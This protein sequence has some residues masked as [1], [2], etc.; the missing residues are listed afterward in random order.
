VSDSRPTARV[1]VDVPD[2]LAR[3]A[4]WVLQTLCDAAGCRLEV[5]RDGELSQG[6]VL[7]YAPRPIGGVPTIPVSAEAAAAIAGGADVPAGSFTGFDSPAPLVGAFPVA[8]AGF[9]LPFDLVASAFVILAAWDEHTRPQ[10]DQ[11]GRFPYELSFFATEAALD[12]ADPPLDGYVRVLR[13]LL[14]QTFDLTPPRWERRSGRSFAAPDDA[15][16]AHPGE[17]PPATPSD[18]APA[19]R[20]DGATF[21]IA[22]THDVDHLRRWT[23]RA[24]AGSLRRAAL[25]ARAGDYATA[26]WEL[27]CLLR[28]LTDHLPA[29]SDPYWTFPDLIEREDRLGVDCTFF[30]IAS[31]RERLD[32]VDASDYH[33]RLPAL[34]RLLRRAARETGLHGNSRDRVDLTALS[35]DRSRLKEMTAGAVEGIRFHYLR[36]LYHETLPML[37][38]AGFAYDSSIAFGAREGPR[39]GLSFPFRPYFLARDR[40]LDLVELPLVI[41]DG[42]LQDRHYRDLPVAEGR[43][44]AQRVLAAV[45]DVGG[46]AAVLWH[47]TRLDPLISRGYGKV[48]WDLI[49]W[50]KANGGVATSA[51]DVVAQWRA[52]V[53]P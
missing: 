24:V 41:M 20:S 8:D 5:V 7:A 25:E 39:C 46:A 49:E 4:A 53:G 19:A 37:E 42:T 44:A 1:F 11:H 40:P 35:E 21:A 9:A 15:P 28:A 6:A 32:G 38:A 33:R 12:A 50:T 13:R 18:A 17:A 45:H 43:A 14:A 47:N 26:R 16:I 48:Y 22:L 36:C 3:K 34:L 30:I 23:A 27:E 29:G 52:A 10:R 2:H 51:G 31:H